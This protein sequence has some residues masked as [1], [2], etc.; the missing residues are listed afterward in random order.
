MV[1]AKATSIIATVTA[2]AAYNA[3]AMFI[4][5]ASNA[6]PAHYNLSRLYVVRGIAAGQG[7][8]PIS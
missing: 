5:L 1:S 3:T 4:D 7:E 6:S 2:M 8:F